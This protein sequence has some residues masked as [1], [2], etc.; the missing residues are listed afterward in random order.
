MTDDTYPKLA[1]L[2]GGEWLEQ[3]SAGTREVTNPATE[4]I[5]GA[6]PLAGPRELD[7]CLES[8]ADGFRRW[9][10]TAGAQRGRVLQRAADVL[11]QR[12]E[13]IGRWLTMEEGKTLTEAKLEIEAAAENLEWNGRQADQIELK[14]SPAPMRGV[15]ATVSSDPVGVVAAFTP[16]NFPAMVPAR[17]IAPALAAGCAVILKP[18]EETPATA[19]G[20]VQALREAGAPDGVVQLVCGDPADVSSRLIASP[21][22]RKISFTGSVPVGKHLAR[23]AA[24]AMK[25]GIWEL[26]G[27]GPA[28][29][30]DDADVALAAT[31]LARFKSRN[32]GQVCTAPSR[33]YVHASIHDA[34]VEAL[35]L[36]LDRLTLG[37]GL[38]AN[39]DVGPLANERRLDAMIRLVDD[40][41][42]RGAKLVRGGKRRG[43]RGFF[44]EL[45]VLTDVSDDALILQEEPFG[46]IAP[47]V[48]FESIDGVIAK[49]N[50][51]PYGLSSYVFT[52]SEERANALVD[53][54]E[55]G[56]VQVNCAAPVRAD[57]PMG[58]VKD[59]GYGY[60]GGSRGI[61][62]YL[63][64]KLVHRPSE[65]LE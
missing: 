3:A 26:G 27:H 59:S 52:Q 54:L 9:R 17:K 13:T 4:E 15:A 38:E 39:V 63:L 16:W 29:V 8:A 60:E 34:F 36:E 64:Q 22:V 6:L 40:A 1:L 58:G 48:R 32:A 61:D 62:E 21:V 18:A 42:A 53:A 23:L 19:M 35:V 56:L 43:D 47:V 12:T 65:V 57:T 55:A 49:A 50:G 28:I 46:P 37:N 20:I 25:P 2:I 44:F 41:L 7:A 24:D 30:L 45:T 5:L 51:L 11:R 33:F 10:K 31:T 14:M